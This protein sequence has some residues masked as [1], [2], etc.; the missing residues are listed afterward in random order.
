[1][2]G[3]EIDYTGSL[4]NTATLKVINRNSGNVALYVQGAYLQT[5]LVVIRPYS[6]TASFNISQTGEVSIRPNSGANSLSVKHSD[7]SEL[8]KIGSD[9][10]LTLG[11]SGSGFGA[12]KKA[13]TTWNP[14]PTVNGLG[15]K[16][17]YD[18]GKKVVFLGAEIP[19]TPTCGGTGCSYSMR[20]CLITLVETPIQN[21][22]QLTP[23]LP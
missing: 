1:M 19:A 9:K 2:I 16:S 6:G 11:E 5:E 7:A 8:F 10:K 4:V 23:L 20:L 14:P 18:F 13:T 17:A 3:K 15:S 12:I 21:L 22:V